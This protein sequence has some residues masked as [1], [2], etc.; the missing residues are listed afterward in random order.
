MDLLGLENLDVVDFKANEHDYAIKVQTKKCTNITCPNMECGSMNFVKNGTK[1]NQFFWDIP[2]SGKRVCLIIDRQ[3]YKCKECGNTWLEEL[4]EVDDDRKMTIRLI[5]YIEMQS[6]YKNRTFTSLADEIGVTEP[7]IKNVFNDIVRAFERQFNPKT[8][9]W[10]GMD[11]IQLLGSPKG[12]ITNVKENTVIDILKDRKQATIIEYLRKMP[13]KGDIQV[14]TM[15][16]CDSYK[17]A[18]KTVLPNAKIVV[19]KFHVLKMAN[20][21]LDKV[22]KELRSTLTSTQRKVLKNERYVLLKRRHDLTV[23]EAISMEAWTKSYPILGEAYELK[24]AFYSIWDIKSKQT[25]KVVL[26][27]WGKS[28]PDSIKQ[29]FEP[30]TTALS[31]WYEEVF[32]Y[33]E[34]KDTTAYTEFLNSILRQIDRIGR[35]YSFDI[36]RVKILYSRG[37]RKPYRLNYEDNLKKCDYILHNN[38]HHIAEPMTIFWGEDYG[39]DMSIILQ[40]LEDREL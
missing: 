17:M 3:K 7:T 34:F 15:D 24:E 29:E 22:R 13:N 23:H 1:K 9:E 28:I 40:K 4:Y 26:E 20:E 36:I 32:N 2:I 19:D 25:A 33:Y 8:P 18:V 31:N 21:C 16:M 37:I 30:L 6:I 5:N 10:L 12:V 39:A 14:V 38:Y 11:E 27:A 35:G